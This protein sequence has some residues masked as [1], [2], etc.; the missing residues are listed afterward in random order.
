MISK[1][2][3]QGSFCLHHVSHPKQLERQND[4]M[5][6][7]GQRLSTFSVRQEIWSYTEGLDPWNE[8][9]AKNYKWSLK[10]C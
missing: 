6:K 1:Y 8:A 9:W 4:I 2:Q 3:G 10:P 5:I 7:D